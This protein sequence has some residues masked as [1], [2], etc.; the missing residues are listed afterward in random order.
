MRLQELTD[1]Q[2]EALPDDEW[3]ELHELSTDYLFGVQFLSRR[4][5][6][7]APGP[8]QLTARQEQVIM[9]VAIERQRQQAAARGR[10]VADPARRAFDAECDPEEA[11][12]SDA[13]LLAVSRR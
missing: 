9:H 10:P 1:A 5:L 3:D 8:D 2:L 4:E 12:M 13:D 6:G 11:D 7:L